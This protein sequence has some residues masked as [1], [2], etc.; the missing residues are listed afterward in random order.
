MT[1]TGSASAQPDQ[2]TNLSKVTAE[3][4]V[5]TIVSDEDP[6]NYFGSVPGIVIQKSTNGDDADEAPGPFIPVDGAVDWTYVVT[7]SGNATLSN[8]VVTDDQ[9]ASPVFVSG[10]PTGTTR[11]TWTRHGPVL[12]HR[13]RRRSASTRTSERSAATGPAGQPVTDD[14]PSHYFGFVSDIEIEKATNGQDA[15]TAPGALRPGRRPGDVDLHRH[16]P[17]QRPD[18]RRRRHRRPGRG[19]DRSSAAT[20]TPTTELDPGETWTYEAH[21]HG[22]R[23]PVHER[24]DGRRL[25]RARGAGHRQRSVQLLRLRRRHRHRQD[26]GRRDRARW[27]AAHVHDHR[28]EHRRGAAHRRHGD[29]S[30]DPRLRPGHRRH[31]GRCSR[32]LHLRRRG[33]DRADRQRRLRRRHS[34]PPSGTVTDEDE[35]AVDAVPPAT[36]RRLRL[37]RRRPRRR[38]GSR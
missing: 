36:D 26:A 25:R 21:R 34:I 37:A 24:R 28:H 23:R 22:D 2:Y 31:G 12:G 19:P 9:R 38:P 13:D 20:R 10:D 14:D 11:S 29:G 27:V 17:G 16:E 32:D 5:G 18:R 1:C 4:P 30:G 15:D 8:V 3:T 7:N 35:A 6:S 33:R